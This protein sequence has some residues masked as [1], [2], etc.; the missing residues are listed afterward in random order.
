MRNLTHIEGGVTAAAG[1]K[2]AGVEAT[3][4]YASRKD[5]ALLVA[6]EPCAVAALYTSNK[7]AAAPVVIDRERSASGVA[8]AVVINSGNA[9][10]CTGLLGLQDAR[11]MGRLTAAALGIDQSL[12]LVCSTGVIGVH[13]PMDKIAT[14]VKKAAAALS[15]DGGHNAACAIMTTDTVKKEVAI[16]L[17]IDDKR[18]VIGGM[19]KGS[20]MIEPNMATMLA[21]I[22]TDAVIAYG[23]LDMAL[24]AAVEISF[25]RIVVDGDQSTNDTVIAMAS[26]KA[27]NRSLSQEHPG[28]ERFVDALKTL[29][30]ELAKKIVM[31]GEGAT[32]F[33]T[34]K[35]S[36]AATAADAQLVARAVAKSPLVK[37]SWFGVDPNWGRV[38][39]AAGYSGAAVE[40]QHVQISIGGIVAYDQGRVAQ[41]GELDAMRRAM[42][43]R[44]FEV[45]INLNLGQGCDTVFTCDLSHDYV[46]INAEYT[47]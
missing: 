17:E 22:T 8:Q 2:A 40:E 37:T 41:T 35:V 23:A 5:M 19:A 31:D 1:F 32:K 42:K 29:C 44:F 36:G 21:F 11:E 30:V 24:R 33:V 18:I 20:G 12:V 4:K 7:V 38:I 26:A 43:A 16:E 25:N 27:G 47:T 13:L 45:E 9:N 39:A 28:W 14:G 10:A 46:S 6:D 3:V 15:H 34:V